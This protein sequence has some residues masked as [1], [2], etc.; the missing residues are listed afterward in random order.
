MGKK[1]MTPELA[2]AFGN[3]LTQ[4]GV[5]MA[6][7]AI[8][9]LMY[10]QG[11]PVD[12]RFPTFHQAKAIKLITNKL[13]KAT[14]GIVKKVG[15][16]LTNDTNMLLDEDTFFKNELA[17]VEGDFRK[18]GGESSFLGPD[19]NQI[20]AYQDNNSF[21]KTVN[22]FKAGELTHLQ[23]LQS[24]LWGRNSL[25]LA[26]LL[27]AEQGAK[28]RD[29]FTL[30]LYGNYKQE[31]KGDKGDKASNL[32]FSDTYID[33]VNKQLSGRYIGLA[34]ADKGQ[35]SYFYGPALRRSGISLNP[36]TNK[37]EFTNSSPETLSI[38]T[39]YLAD[40]LH[41]MEVARKTIYGQ[42]AT[43]TSEAIPPLADDKQILYYHYYQVAP[44]KGTFGENMDRIEGNAFKSFLFPTLHTTE[45]VEVDGV[46]MTQN[47]LE[48]LGLTDANGKL[49]PLSKEALDNNPE[50]KDFL[51]T[52]FIDLVRAEIGTAI[53]AGLL[54]FDNGKLTNRLI[55]LNQLNEKGG[56]VFAVMGDYVL[57]SLIGNVE[58]TKMFNGD[59]ALFKVKEIKEVGTLIDAS[60]PST[61]ENTVQW[62]DVDM[63]GDFRKRIP[64]TSAS[65]KD[66]RIYN[67]SNGTPAVRSF[68]NSATVA[69]IDG[70]GS[71]FFAGEDGKFNKG[72]LE[73][74][75]KAT[76]LPVSELEKLF[77]PYLGVNVTDAQA[78]ITLPVYK[79]RLLGLGKWSPAH[80]DAYAAMYATDET[81][82][83]EQVKL[84]AMPLKTVH[85]ELVKTNNDVMSLHYNKQSEAVLLP[86]MTKGTQLENLRLAMEAEDKFDS[87]G[88][89][90]SKGG[91]DHVIVLDGKKAGG[92]GITDISDGNGNIV[93]NPTFNST[94]LSYR[95]L[96]LQQD[97]S[98]KGTKQTVVGSQGVKNV[99]SVVNPNEMYG[100]IN[101][102]DLIDKYHEVISQLSDIGLNSYKKT[103]GY[104]E[105]TGINDKALRQLL[106]NEFAGEIS[107]NHID[108]I[109]GGI[110]L[111][112]LPISKKIQNKLHAMLTKKSV[113]LKQLGGAMVQLSDFGFVGTEVDMDSKVK[114]G[115][116]WLKDPKERL[117]PMRIDEEGVVHPA[118]ILMP[119]SYLAKEL[120]KQNIDI[121][122]M[123]H[124]EIMKLIPKEVL[125]G[126][127]YRIPNQGPSSNDAFEIVGILPEEAG[128]TM[129]AYSAITTKTGSDFD[130]DKAFVILPNFSIDKEGR[131]FYV[132]DNSPKG[133]ENQR[134]EMMRDMLMHPS[135]Y[136][137]VMAP[138]DDPWLEKLAT[139]I[140]P[141]KEKLKN[142]QFFTGN[143]QMKTKATFDSAKSL[144]GT[145][146]NHMTHHSL[147]LSEG[148][149]FNDYYLG[150]GVKVGNNT[151]LS[152]K[153]DEN[154]NNVA[155]TLGAF[156]NAIVDAAKDPYI[157]RANI[158][159]FTANTA[160]MMARAGISREWIVSFMGQPI[161]KELVAYT[162]DAEGKFAKKGRNA[163]GEI[164]KPLDVLLADYDFKGNIHDI[165]MKY[166]DEISTTTEEL[167]ANLTVGEVNK[168]EQIKILGQ[169]LE[170]QK[171][172]KQLNEVVKISK[173]D[174]DGATKNQG[175]AKL[176]ENLLRKV[177]A[178]D[179]VGNVDKLM[180]YDV[181]NGEAVFNGSRM[182][183]TYFANSVRA[184]R[185]MYEGMFVSNSPAVEN[186]TD[187]MASMSG[188][189][190]LTPG[191]QS[192][193]VD[194]A[195][196]NEAYA[197][198]ATDTSAFDIAADVKEGSKYSE[199]Q[200][201]LHRL[202]F[203]NSEE[204]SLAERLLE[205][206]YGVHKDNA[207]I[208]AL[209]VRAG[210]KNK[211]SA[212]FLPK[213][214][215]LKEAKDDLYLAWEELKSENHYLADDLM[216][217][218]F[219]ASG[220]S[221]AIGSFYEHIPMQFLSD[222]H[223]SDQI[224]HKIGEYSNPKFL[225][226]KMDSI[227]KHL[228]STDQL[229]PTVIDK[230][231]FRM[232]TVDNKVAIP[233]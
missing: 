62:A 143:N 145:I 79:E 179:A 208:N 60:K 84:L 220:M 178:D 38:L 156:M 35:Q 51:G 58:Q 232:K 9:K 215:A 50:V 202:L 218:S 104:S 49:V 154:D 115:I 15:T 96:F 39:G 120:K 124:S 213:G 102:R 221:K 122:G 162:A 30:D 71:E 226:G 119:H 114:D 176:T 63:F 231:Y 164:I 117:Q 126:F 17:R 184:A 37:V 196:K 222:K 199:G 171:K 209:E 155:N 45:T 24:S 207:L 137:A 138:L 223:F 21:S 129:V 193:E 177:I 20:W 174:T 16:P 190:Y 134:L 86:I 28:N 118:Q 157:T 78:W 192:E 77:K 110:N 76:N 72:N 135:A 57:N 186:L 89:L 150:K 161:L 194:S 80:E 188:Y 113:K 158:N 133:L 103:I 172:A 47:K 214:E 198:T 6:D 92:V 229:V 19:G 101:G 68:Y 53:E 8:T 147:A 219:Y 70:I 66:F 94:K 88:K 59:P 195:I 25:W 141:V 132:K 116:V 180:G 100:E 40:E 81:P 46:E 108:A 64:S 228:S 69:N 131:V 112:A 14:R 142:L 93:A 151:S 165:N 10:N 41:R 130:I 206:K 230:V 149:Y 1:A 95:R 7:K 55:D 34:E 29:A 11:L 85:N 144:V 224:K 36:L 43:E 42:E 106:A 233:T 152:N 82:T 109:L 216:L 52:S 4:L 74:I 203:G 127:S 33:Q 31:D 67:H 146:A 185:I 22:E 225:E 153:V 107:D 168:A 75:S 65:G 167:Q 99:L 189:V 27:H 160:F 187:L 111:D 159:Q 91:P 125:E 5:T 139:K 56:D 123:T 170:W 87:N 200:I 2:T 3:V 128:D 73:R 121:K 13:D 173:S 32:K 169:F 90:I 217:Y 105:E 227:Y 148:L 44:G 23:D 211:P 12:P 98:T 181:V 210:D 136:A 48:Q 83:P 175:T 163:K 204:A 205:A 212:I 201:G 197:M 183:G 18:L 191:A 182:T 97:L 166:M 61:P 140:F 26:E 54:N